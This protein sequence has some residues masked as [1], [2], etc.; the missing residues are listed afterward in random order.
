MVHKFFSLVVI[1]L[2]LTSCNERPDALEEFYSQIDI[3][4]PEDLSTPDEDLPFTRKRWSAMPFMDL[5]RR[6]VKDLTKNYLVKGQ[7]FDENKFRELI[8]MPF[9]NFEK[10]GYHVAG[11][12]IGADIDDRT[13]VFFIIHENKVHDVIFATVKPQLP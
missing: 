2:I 8:A 13:C 5:K 6:I 4:A 3:I 1:L 9:Y 7:A 11:Y 12:P 10:D